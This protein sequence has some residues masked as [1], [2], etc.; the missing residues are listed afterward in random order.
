MGVKAPTP[1][2]HEAAKAPAPAPRHKVVET[3]IAALKVI[4]V[5]KRPGRPPG[6]GTTA[7]FTEKGNPKFVDVTPTDEPKRRNFMKRT[8]TPRK[9]TDI[10]LDPEIIRAVRLAM[11]E[12][13]KP[14][15][16]L[17]TDALRALF[18]EVSTNPGAL[19]EYKGHC[20]TCLRRFKT[21]RP[22]GAKRRQRLSITLTDVDVAA[23]DYIADR[24]FGGTYSRALEAAIVFYLP[25]WLLPPGAKER[26]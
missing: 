10:T 5:S 14:Q 1:V 19:A 21:Q 13:R 11:R 18:V 7:A 26:L 4:P 6:G 25:E 15:P 24:W 3:D 8:E 16:A 12:M 22:R 2:K 9:N 17:V 20:P 23:L